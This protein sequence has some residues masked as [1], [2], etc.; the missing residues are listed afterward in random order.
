MM[1][2]GYFR[3]GCGIISESHIFI[4]PDGRPYDDRICYGEVIGP[5]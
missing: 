5:Q 4:M 1:L 3:N 2:R